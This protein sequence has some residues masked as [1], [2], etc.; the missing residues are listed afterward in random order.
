MPTALVVETNYLI[1]SVIQ[2]PLARQGY[3]V[4]IAT[5][6]AEA[7]GLIADGG[8]DIALIDFRLQHREPGG[9]VGKLKQ[10]KIPSIFC[11]AASPDEVA[12]KFPG[13]IVLAKPF[14]DAA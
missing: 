10:T 13:V 12:E 8:I 2:R 11:T 1:A 5:S 4:L 9:V 7:D 14:S 6:P 3:T